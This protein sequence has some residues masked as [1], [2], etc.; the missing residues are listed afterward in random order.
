MCTR[1]GAC[2][3]AGGL[4]EAAQRMQQRQAVQTTQ[5]MALQKMRYSRLYEH[6]PFGAGVDREQIAKAIGQALALRP[7]ERIIMNFARYRAVSAAA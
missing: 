2:T 3:C 1:A 7:H 5:K 4:L 6:A